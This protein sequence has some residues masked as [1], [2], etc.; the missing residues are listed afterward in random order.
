MH[1]MGRSMKELLRLYS[2]LWSSQWNMDK[3]VIDSLEHDHAE[4]HKCQVDDDNLVR[5]LI[6]C[7]NSCFA[8]GK[9]TKAL[10]SYF[11]AIRVINPAITVGWEG[12]ESSFLSNLSVLYDIKTMNIRTSKQRFHIA[13]VLVNI[14]AVLLE[15]EKINGAM[16]VF[17]ESL[18]LSRSL[19]EMFGAPHQMNMGKRIFRNYDDDLIQ[20][21]S[22]NLYADILQNMGLVYLRSCQY[23]SA[24]DKFTQSIASRRSALKLAQERKDDT[25]LLSC[26]HALAQILQAYGWTCDKRG[27]YDESKL[28]YCEA[29]NLR[30]DEEGK[31]LIPLLAALADSY[32]KC[33]EFQDAQY[34]YELIIDMNKQEENSTRLIDITIKL[35]SL[36]QVQE[37]YPDALQ[38]ARNAFISAVNFSCNSDIQKTILL[39]AAMSNLGELYLH[40]GNL[41]QAK[42]WFKMSLDERLNK[43]ELANPLIIESILSLTSVYY[44][45]KDFSRLISIYS[46]CIEKYM[47]VLGE[48][49]RYVAKLTDKLGEAYANIEEYETAIVLHDQ[50]RRRMYAASSGGKKNHPDLA[51]I[52]RSTAVT[53]CK[54]GRKD[55]GFDIFSEAL[56]IFHKCGYTNGHP[57]VAE[58]LRKIDSYFAEHG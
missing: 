42:K 34:S 29:L 21:H 12:T 50:A 27:L 8:S 20:L 9:Y 47:Q 2:L 52:L 57:E 4:A 58:T 26:R 18:L 45:R 49:H 53:Y 23:E 31:S 3:D 1:V 39:S 41:L 55:E 40:Q 43:L 5:N 6:A 48:N 14:G 32:V 25:A 11:A 30:F 56:E 19:V 54:A 22:L 15:K 44:S 37:K 46:K 16:N 10:E 38:Y 51:C 36:C 24:Q 17:Q 28:S 13:K 7:G 35:S 33:Q